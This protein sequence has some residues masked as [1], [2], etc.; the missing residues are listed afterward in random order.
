MVDCVVLIEDDEVTRMLSGIVIQKA[1]FAQNIL[2]FGNGKQALEYY[3]QLAERKEEVGD[4]YPRLIFLDLYLPVMGGW[5]FLDEFVRDYYPLFKETKVVVLSSSVDPVDERKAQSYP[6]VL[7]FQ[8]KPIT[9]ELM[10]RLT[11]Q[12]QKPA[13]VI[14]SVGGDTQG[15]RAF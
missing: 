3:R 12:L 13:T 6:L 2:S 14:R 4:N 8:S 1:S 10:A 9:K 15:L 7:D 11:E 5:E